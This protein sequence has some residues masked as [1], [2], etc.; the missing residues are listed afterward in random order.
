MT[1]EKEDDK[2]AQLGGNEGW[3]KYTK[4]QVIDALIASGTKSGAATIL[5]CARN[6]ITSYCDED[7]EIE[8]AMNE[9]KEIFVDVAETKLMANVKKGNQTAIN[10]VLGTLGKDR[11]YV[12]R[13]EN[14]GK[15]G[16]PIESEIIVKSNNQKIHDMIDNL[17]GQVEEEKVIAKKAKKK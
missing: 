6:T 12:K 4:K 16:A 10:F 9:A 1:D 5:G 15:N 7:P 8:N 17:T 13:V 14:T 3:R 11:G 2:A